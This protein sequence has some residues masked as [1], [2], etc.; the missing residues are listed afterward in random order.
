MGNVW[1]QLMILAVYSLSSQIILATALNP[2]V[3]CAFGNVFDGMTLIRTLD[4]Q[5]S[6]I[7]DI[8]EKVAMETFTI[9]IAQVL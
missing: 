6:W 8:F 7:F 4:S 5:F 9:R 3:R 1:S 2:R